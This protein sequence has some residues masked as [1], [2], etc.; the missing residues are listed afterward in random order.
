VEQQPLERE[1]PEKLERAHYSMSFQKDDE[2]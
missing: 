1:L 2:T